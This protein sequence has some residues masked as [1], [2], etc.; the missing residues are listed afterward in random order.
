MMSV[1]EVVT[2]DISHTNNGNGN[3]DD[4][5]NMTSMATLRKYTLHDSHY[6]I[7]AGAVSIRS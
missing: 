3:D 6:D 5:K 2:L 7:I 4:E 1:R